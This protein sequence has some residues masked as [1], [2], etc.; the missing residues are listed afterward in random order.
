MTR[1]SLILLALV[2]GV[3]WLSSGWTGQFG[4]IKQQSRRP[5]KVIT[6]NDNG[7]E[8]RVKQGD[9]FRIE[10]EA[11][12]A[13]GYQWQVQDL[14]TSRLDLINQS[15]RVLLSDGRMGGPVVT[16]FSFRAISEGSVVLTIDYYRPWEDR[17]KSEKTFSVKINI[18]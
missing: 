17:G 18:V 9:L 15:T 13:T 1:T 11:P 14:D 7:K 2:I 4:E 6:I 10:L 12:G 16:V 3:A 8:I 5:V